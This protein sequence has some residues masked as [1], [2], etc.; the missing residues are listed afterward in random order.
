[1]ALV[2]MQKRLEAPSDIS[3]LAVRKL[4]AAE[5]EDR[6]RAQETKLVGVIFTPET[7]PSHWLVDTFVE[8]LEQNTLIYLR[9]DQCT[10][11]AQ[12][13]Q[14]KKD[15]QV[16]LDA[17]GTLKL[18]ARAKESSC[19]VTTHVDLLSAW[20]RRSLALDLARLANFQEIEGWV[21][22]LFAAQ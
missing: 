19:A 1:M 5:R 7:R 17:S 10:S 9:P 2:E 15:P 13:M 21:Q 6:Q 18:N 14:S 16:Q 20:R 4:P 3:Q 8:M 11:R 12:E 22:H